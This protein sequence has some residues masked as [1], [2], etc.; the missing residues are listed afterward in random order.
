MF[1]FKDNKVGINTTPFSTLDINGNTKINGTLNIN[2]NL[3]QNGILFSSDG[4]GG[5]SSQW[6]DGVDLSIYYN[7]G[8]VG[9]GTN[10]P[11]QKLDVSGN[12]LISGN[13]SG[14][15]ISASGNISGANISASGNISGANISVSGD[16]S[17][18]NINF[19]GNL[20]QNG[21]LFTGTGG[22]G[23][24]SQWSDG[25]NNII[26]YNSGNVGVGTSN[27]SKELDISGNIFVSKNVSCAN[28]NLSGNIYRNNL[29]LSTINT[30]FIR[31]AFIVTGTQ[32]S[33]DLSYNGIIYSEETEIEVYVNGYKLA[34]VNSTTK[35]YTLTVI[36]D[37]VN[38]FTTFRVTLDEGALDGDIVD[39]VVLPGLKFT[40]ETP[41]V[42]QSGDLLGTVLDPINGGSIDINISLV[43]N[44]LIE[45]SNDNNPLVINFL[46]GSFDTSYVGKKG[47]IYIRER[48]VSGRN[49]TID[50]RLY[51]NSSFGMGKT[52]DASTNP[53]IDILEYE[54]I[55][56]DLVVGK[57]NKHINEYV[58]DD[59]NK[60]LGIGTDIP[61]QQLDVS[62]NALIRGNISGANISASGDISTSNI[63]FSGNLYQNGVLFT[64]LGGGGSSQWS[65]GSNN[66]IY[67]NSGNVGIGTITPLQKLDVLGNIAASGNISA[68][69]F[70]SCANINYTGNLYKAGLFQTPLSS[71][72]INSVVGWGE[73]G[74]SQTTI[75]VAAQT[76]IIAIAGGSVHS[77]AL[78]TNGSVIVWGNNDY[79][80]VTIPVAAQSGVVAISA[81]SY[82]SLALK[83]DGSVIGWGANYYSQT[84]IPVAA[85]SG[86]IAI[87]ASGEHS[88]A[89]KNDGSVI[90]WG[91]N[92][93][94]QVTIPVAAQSGVIAIAAGFKHS[95]AL[96]NNGSVIGWGLNTNNQVT[97]PVAAQSGVIAIAAGF[98]HSLALKNDGSV[99]GWGNNGVGQI[100]IPVG[101]Q[102]GV[103][104]IATGS[105]HSLALKT[106]GSVIGW[107]YDFYGQ[108]IIPVKAQSGII[109]IAGGGYHSLALKSVKKSYILEN[110]GIGTIVPQAILDV[111]GN[112]YMSN[113]TAAAPVLTFSSNTN[114]GIY[115]AGADILGLTTGG[116]E[117]IRVDASGNI[118]IGT[119]IPQQKLDVSGNIAASGNISAGNI[120]FTG[121]LYKNNVIFAGSWIDGNNKNMDG[122]MGTVQC[123]GKNEGGQLNVPGGLSN[124]VAIVGGYYNS[125]A[126]RSNGTIQGWGSG[127][128]AIPLDASSNVIAI[129]SRYYYTLALKSNGIVVAWGNNTYGQT[130]LPVGLSNVI[131]IATGNYH[132][133]ALKSDGSVVGWGWNASGQISI[134]STALTNVIAIAAGG[135][136]SLALKSDGTVVGWGDNGYGQASFSGGLSNVIAIAAGQW[137][138]LALKSDGTVVACGYS[139]G[140][141]NNQTVVPAGLSNVIA[142]AAGGN[143]NL[144]LKSDG[145]IVGWGDNGSGQITIPGG[146][147]NIIAIACGYN[148]SLTISA[149]SNIKNIQYCYATNNIGIGTNYPI[150]NLDVS[151]N[152]YFRGNVGIGT[153]TP[154]QKLDVSGNAFIRGDI[155]ASNINFSGNLYQNGVLFT[156]GTSSQWTTGIGSNIYYNSGNVGIGTLI[157]QQKLDVSGNVF[158]RGNISGANISASGDISASNINFSGNLY[159]NGVL[160]TGGVGGGGSSQWTTTGSNIYY[161]TGNVG[162]G[163]NNPQAA[164]DVAGVVNSIV[165]QNSWMPPVKKMFTLPTGGYLDVATAGNTSAKGF[166]GGF[167]DGRYVYLVPYSYG[168]N[169]N[170]GIF[171]R[172]EINNFTVSGVTYLDLTTAGNTGAKGFLGGFT[173]GRYAYLVPNINGYIVYH[174]IVTRVDLTN[175]T[176]SGVSYLDLSTVDT[177]A[178][179]FSG[180]FTD[181]QYAYFVPY[182]GISGNIARV[183]LNNFTT[184]GVSFL[185]VSTAGDTTAKGF[186]GG[187]INGHYAYFVPHYDGTR[188]NS[189]FTRVDINNFTT[190]GV[191]YVNV[192]AG[193]TSARGFIGGFTDGRYA[194][195][196]PHQVDY[197]SFHGILTRV[198]LNNFTTSGVTYLDVA[199]AGNTSATG[200]KGGFTDG[201]YA[202]LV[203]FNYGNG[204]AAVN[205]GIFT[206]V[207]LTNFTTSG[208]SYL[209]VSTAGNT[210]AKGFTGGFTDGKYAYLVPYYNVNYHG[211]LTRVLIAD[212]YPQGY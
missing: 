136:H 19:S 7:S 206:R 204:G 209:D 113:G 17:T 40:T 111:S 181:G 56:S 175:F 115:R 126:L 190:S 116:V 179:G 102:S 30:S 21:V 172:V 28:I 63:N 193:N 16:I 130:T 54:I 133:L 48:C 11:L 124:V 25:S 36:N 68:G 83:T 5:G 85:Q 74:S 78:K 131:G 4:N 132:G 163:T 129:A 135:E 142:I 188:Y 176:T 123:W 180:G 106:D 125:F 13:I 121:N 65:D 39:I 110:V 75:P 26:F 108:T 201:R 96:K 167:T 205:H 161:N 154:L 76:D 92:T 192:R 144:V 12:A 37:V 149:N 22:G 128:I 159:Q 143:F 53:V 148:H 72:F 187:F 77:L 174:G 73:N 6:S 94:N 79:G 71:N 69:N 173:D 184:S 202:Y 210:N 105:S 101:A 194:Y 60:R 104:A 100:T 3:L 169:G 153:I 55:K 41:S 146:L 95:L 2:G 196:V 186:Q 165:F 89:L 97:I 93:N 168:F 9:I 109:A 84:T 31:R 66:M 171:T 197:A 200:F 86:V 212:V 122:Y 15:N 151:G 98:S 119:L 42:Y 140:G 67:Y 24:S 91:L 127:D 145:S 59:V 139:G 99:I 160:F 80:Q 49:I 44:A 18:S 137:H 57:Y 207:D 198:D 27:P 82:Y 170:H 88:L 120:N 51:F 141:S 138:S 81:G 152:S 158:I 62:G 107:G 162:I 185:D 8:N 33:F 103:V 43:P 20:Y 34:Y 208:V 64:G 87:A 157:P 118:G 211:I 155:S 134:P 50:N 203:P 156:G 1:H 182:V 32:I 112:I 178:K 38:N 10:N 150:S 195:L 183:N 46:P 199:N 189:T 35:D 47:R 117:R 23:G 14:A 166:T 45:L 29:L 164:L 147:T 58:W 114:T 52:S 61:L 70:V 90:G 191:T 177:N